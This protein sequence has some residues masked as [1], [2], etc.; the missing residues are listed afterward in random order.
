MIAT[1][2]TKYE[3][4]KSSN[5]KVIATENIETQFNATPSD[6]MI[7]FVRATI[8]LHGAWRKN[9]ETLVQRLIYR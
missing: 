4:F 2:S 3:I 6:S 5:K 1:V 7:G 9:I 8:A